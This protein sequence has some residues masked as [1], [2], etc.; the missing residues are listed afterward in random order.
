MLRKH[1]ITGPVLLSL[2]ESEIETLGISKFGTRRQLYLSINDLLKTGRQ[3]P[4]QAN[5][6]QQLS[7][8]QLQEQ[9]KEDFQ[10]AYS[11]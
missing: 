2:T 11:Y 4:I 10:R 5:S 8:E 3:R 1:Q 7:P 9:I 6:P